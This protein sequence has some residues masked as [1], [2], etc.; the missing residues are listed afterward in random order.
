MA[1]GGMLPTWYLFSGS[2]LEGLYTSLKARY[3]VENKMY[4]HCMD[5]AS[6]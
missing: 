5:N 6:G 1:G 4:A 2:S 3:S